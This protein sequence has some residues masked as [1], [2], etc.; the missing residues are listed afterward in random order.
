MRI[1]APPRDDLGDVG[2]SP[3]GPARD[4][5]PETQDHLATRAKRRLG[6]S[7]R[8]KYRLD[9][10]LG[11]GGMGAVF[12]A[13]QRIGGVYAVKILHEGLAARADAQQS[14]LREALLANRVGILSSRFVS[15]IQTS[16][17]RY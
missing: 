9:R 11:T 14:F 5:V 7:L 10:V 3:P 12:A 16:T 13:T 6:T 8:G 15:T 1:T 17:G 2:E 4:A